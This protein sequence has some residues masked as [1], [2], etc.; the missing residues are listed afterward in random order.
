[1][2]KLNSSCRLAAG[3]S[4]S[5]GLALSAQALAQGG[6]EG[7]GSE[8]AE[9][10]VFSPATAQAEVPE[11]V[12]VA[13]HRTV[14]FTARD[15]ITNPLENETIALNLFDGLTLTGVRDRTFATENADFN[16]VGGIA[17]DEFAS[18]TFVRV[19]DVMYGIIDS[20]VYGKFLIQSANQN[21]DYLII[22]VDTDG[23]KPCGNDFE[24]ELWW[25]ESANGP[26]AGL[27]ELPAW[28]FAGEPMPALEDGML[29]PRGSELTEIDVLI[30]YTPG[31]LTA[32]GGNPNSMIAAMQSWE[33]NT[34]T[35]YNNSGVE[36]RIRIVHLAPTTYVESTTNMGTDLS[37]LRNNGDGQIDEVHALRNQYGADL[38][39]LVTRQAVAGTC[40]IAYLLFPGGNSATGFGVTGYTCGWSTFAH[41][42]GHNMGCAHDHNNGSSGY[43]C[44]SFGH[45]TPNNQYRTIMSYAPGQRI[46]YFSTPLRTFGG[47]VLG[48]SEADGCGN[49][50]ATDNTRSMNET[51]FVVSNFRQS[52]VGNP[53]P[54]DFGVVEPANN[55]IAVQLSGYAIQWEDSQFAAT[56][57]FALSTN[58]D[59]SDPIVEANGLTINAWAV[60]PGTL[61]FNTQYYWS[62]HAVGFGGENDM[63]PEVATFRTRFE[64]DLNSDGSV[65]FADLNLVLAQFGQSGSNL[66][67]DANKDGVVN[68]TDLNMVLGTF[69]SNQ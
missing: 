1:M 63:I 8:G 15:L 10:L 59:M 68:F 57:D 47:F 37:R 58:S 17:E 40:G 24:H 60:A 38:V 33:N 19:A 22:E 16:W 5:A 11:G 69:G 41:E 49:N 20:P 13:R 26:E 44:F 42:L 32:V 21:D 52:V 3:I 54:V 46:N 25:D 4:F 6:A 7:L 36:Q 48:I 62:V 50:T 64:T 30:V 28:H 18:A 53:P 27:P 56:Y 51:R 2:R 61:A 12:L 35:A 45:R 39:H 66:I 9:R 34:N 55:A 23:I 29:D 14:E 31:A 43:R 65:N 67:G